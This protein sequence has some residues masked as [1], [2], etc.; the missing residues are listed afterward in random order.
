VHDR[1]VNSTYH[2]AAVN[3]S[4]GVSGSHY[5]AYCDDVAS[6]YKTAI[7]TLRDSDQIATVIAA[8]NDGFTD[9]LGYPACVSSAVSVA[10][11]DNTDAVAAYSNTAPFVT[12][13]APGDSVYSSIPVDA[14]GYMSGTS[15]AA[16]QVTGALAVLQSKF[17]HQATVAQLLT[18]LQKTGKAITANGYTRARIDVGA[19]V[20]D[21]FLDGFGD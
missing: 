20:D 4:F 8:G 3:I 6:A 12:F 7:D 14:Y 17:A 5:T 19:A 1:A 2:I 11:T 21:I 13:Y 18:L 9:G 16:P 15:M 10:A